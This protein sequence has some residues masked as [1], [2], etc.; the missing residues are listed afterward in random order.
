GRRG[1]RARQEC[2]EGRGG[3]RDSLHQVRLF[4]VRRAPK[5]PRP[6]GERGWGEGGALAPS[7]PSPPTPLPRGA[8]GDLICKYLRPAGACFLTRPQGRRV[9]AEA[10]AA[11][12]GGYA[13]GA[14]RAGGA[15]SMWTSTSFTV[16][17]AWVRRS[18]TSW[19]IA[20]PSRTVISGG[21]STWMSTR[22]SRPALRT[23][24]FSSPTTPG[25]AA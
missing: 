4:A 1:A 9:E 24:S 22:Y 15:G 12:R 5:A 18:L 7:S 3:P 8:R 10:T 2:D 23:S 16:T 17:R 25:T 21:T 20:W 6:W 14:G 19:A 13:G 11:R